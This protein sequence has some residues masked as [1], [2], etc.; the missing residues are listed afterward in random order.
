MKIS[1]KNMAFSVCLSLLL[2]CSESKTIE[3]PELE[4]SV[5]S[6]EKKASSKR[7]LTVEL[8]ERMDKEQ[9]TK[10]AAYLKSIDPN[11]EKI[12]IN[13]KI[14]DEKRQFNWAV[15]TVSPDI[16]V[17]ILG[18]DI[19]QEKKL[20]EKI[21]NYQLPNGSE[22][23]GRWI[24]RS[25]Y[26]SAMIFYK[27]NGQIIADEVFASGISKINFTQQ[28]DE[29]GVYF[30]KEDSSDGYRINK[31]GSMDVLNVDEKRKIY[32]IYPI[33]NKDIK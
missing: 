17:T 5:V 33:E 27:Q 15:A 16:Q 14:K 13:F 26:D 22:L 11:Y 19:D 7:A 21:S 2:G 29:N 32:T 4:F 25:S 18:S 8:D 12:F 31:D 1:S 9:L 20:Q 23:I 24:K 3:K 30:K 28:S 10:I 6:D